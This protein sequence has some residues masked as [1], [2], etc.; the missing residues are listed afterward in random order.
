MSGAPAIADF[1]MVSVYDHR[2]G[3]PTLCIRHHPGH[4]ITVLDYVH[5]LKRHSLFLIVLTGLLGVGSGVLA[6]NQYFF[7]HMSPLFWITCFS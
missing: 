4:R 1:D 6:E 3:L 5:I 2:Y 7:L